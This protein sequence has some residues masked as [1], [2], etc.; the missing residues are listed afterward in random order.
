MDKGENDMRKRIATL[1]TALL[2]GLAS[3]AM[4]QFCPGCIQNSASPQNAQFNVSSGVIRGLLTVS[5]EVVTNLSV[6]NLAVANL[7]GNG[8]GITSLNAS[9]LTSGTIPT[10]RLSGSYTGI[11]GL[12]TI[13]VGTWT[14]TV[15]GT[16]YGGTGQNFVTAPTGDIIY[17]SAPG[18]MSVLAPST[19]GQVLQTNGAAAPSWTGAPQIIGTN[20]SSIPLINLLSGNLPLNI[21]VNDA[22]ISTISASKIVGNISGSATALSVP[23]PIGNLAAGPLP[24]SIPASSITVTGVAPGTYGGP[25]QIPQITVRPDGRLSFATQYLL[26]VPPSFISTGAIPIGVTIPASQISTGTLHDY[27]IATHIADNG[28]GAG[29]YGDPQHSVQLTI[30]SDGRVYIATQALTAI[31][32]NQILAGALP[33][34]VTVN[35]TTISTGTLHDYVVATKIINSGVSPGIYGNFNQIPQ[36]TVGADGRITSAQQFLVPG[37]S[38][39]SVSADKDNN[40]NHSQTSQAGSSW[41]FHGDISALSGIFNNVSGDGNGLT[42]LSPFALSTGTLPFGVTASSIA[43]NTVTNGQVQVGANIDEAKIANLVSDLASKLN[44]TGGTLTGLLTVSS[45]VV[46]SDSVTAS[47]FFGDGSHLTGITTP[48]LVTATGTATQFAYFDSTTHLLSS[49]AVTIN[50]TTMRIGNLNT[51]FPTSD[52]HL[53]IGNGARAFNINLSEDPVYL[54]MAG[55]GGASASIGFSS[56]GNKKYILGKTPHGN[57]AINDEGAG[58]AAVF[59]IEDGTK[60]VAIGATLSGDDIFADRE[61]NIYGVT[62]MRGTGATQSV[63]ANDQGTMYFDQGNGT[64]PKRFLASESTGNYNV[65]AKV[66]RLGPPGSERPIMDANQ[67]VYAY[68]DSVMQST[69]TFQFNGSSLTLNTPMLVT[70]TITA[71]NFVGDGSG[72]TGIIA[73]SGSANPTGPAGGDLTGTYPNPTIPTLSVLGISTNSLQVQI[74]ALDVSTA[75]LQTQINNIVVSSANLQSQV[76]ALSISTNTIQTEINGLFISTGNLQQGL[77]L[78]GASTAAL[79]LIDLSIGT[80]T[81]NLQIQLTNV[82]ADTN[83]LHSQLLLVGTSTNSLQ[84]QITALG[85]STNT[86]NSAMI[87]GFNAVGASTN[88]LQILIT[89]IGTST[90]SL[91]IQLNNVALATATIAS[92]TGTLQANDVALSLSTAAL[93][94]TINLIGTSTGNLQIQ[95]TNVGADTAT[96]HTQIVAVGASTN[97]LNQ[98]KASTGTNADILDLDALTTIAGPFTVDVGSVT[99]K[100]GLGV[101]GNLTDTSGQVVFGSTIASDAILTVV[102]SQSIAGIKVDQ[103][104]TDAV[105]A[106]FVGRKAEGTISSLSP[107][108]AGDRLVTFGGLGYDGATPFTSSTT[109][110]LVFSSTENY[111]ASA[112]GSF[113]QILTTPSGST[114]PVVSATFGPG[115]FIGGNGSGITGIHNSSFTNIPNQT[116]TNNAFA[117]CLTGSSVTITSLAGSYLRVSL[118][119]AATNTNNNTVIS[120]GLRI[121]G[122]NT[123]QFGATPVTKM[124]VTPAASPVSTSIDTVIDTALTAGSHTA[125]LMAFTSANT[126]TI[127][128]DAT[129]ITR[130]GITEE[131]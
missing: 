27:V 61:L 114:T 120:F 128:N 58:G 50:G 109:A 25:I 46:V 56:S 99:M 12:G 26:S 100:F 20:V 6:T 85:A 124:Q 53:V 8:S 22:S 62:E 24:T 82:G 97:T 19:A 29:V 37:I 78:V 74:T 35:P 112:H 69:P 88:S 32:T 117:G 106:A 14:G 68:S 15:V 11:T 127:V 7:L 95:L 113:G 28:V 47:A 43:A 131:R 108:L 101:I 63:S 105:G 3:R 129:A 70:D 110:R 72:L 81:G 92:S 84:T 52:L 116:F 17:F 59:Y 86:L 2:I 34:N 38:T 33:L 91:Q 90:G 1:A 5:S 51:G 83:T 55:G 31:N 18:V 41:T 67:V 107:V 103:Y 76:A 118:S 65:L 79:H 122:A 36:F 57:F 66:V 73:S 71:H 77:V 16:Q 60:H 121:D 54:E 96:N 87:T 4:A 45:S 94:T 49:G 42:N 40:W 126:A 89:S 98:I 123:N 39:V 130:F 75:S 115:A 44:L 10:G 104:S 21:A 102:Q 125:C 13:T 119:G 9:Q 111:S 80:S 64:R 23:L 93:K 30:G 48:G